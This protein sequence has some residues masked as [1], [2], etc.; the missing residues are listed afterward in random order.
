MA[1]SFQL[2][3]THVRQIG[4]LPPV[5]SSELSFPRHQPRRADRAVSFLEHELHRELNVPRQVS[6]RAGRVPPAGK[7]ALV[8]N[9]ALD[10]RLAV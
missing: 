7:I 4:N 8:E 10:K 3:E 2:A 6:I 9:Q 1:P 5:V